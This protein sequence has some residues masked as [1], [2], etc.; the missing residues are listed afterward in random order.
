M[1]EEKHRVGVISNLRAEEFVFDWPK[2]ILNHPILLEIFVMTEF[3]EAFR[4]QYDWNVNFREIARSADNWLKFE[5]LEEPPF[6]PERTIKLSDIFR[7]DVRRENEY[8]KV[9]PEAQQLAPVHSQTDGGHHPYN[10]PPKIAERYG[11]GG[12]ETAQEERGNP[13]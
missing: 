11:N 4:D 8:L 2:N 10:Y 1:T 13:S 3:R 7:E 12:D 6:F 9:Y 5:S